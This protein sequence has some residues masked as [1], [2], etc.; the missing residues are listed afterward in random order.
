MIVAALS[1]T[2][3]LVARGVRAVME[4]R[5]GLSTSMRGLFG[6]SE[7]KADDATL[8][9]LREA[10]PINHIK[11]GLPPFL[12]VH[13][14]GD[15]SVLYNWSP[16]FQAKLKEAG[17]PCDLITI[18]DGAHGMAR[19]DGI[20]PEYKDKVADWLQQHLRGKQ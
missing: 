18:P 3:W 6:R 14:S 9:I 4:R 5:G 1:F 8:H 15:M 7:A 10:S 11:S 19:W 20:M 16:L 17:V 2:G 12:L 13:G